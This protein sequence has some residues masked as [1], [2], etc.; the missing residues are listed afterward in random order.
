MRWTNC[1]IPTLKEYPRDATIPSHQLLIKG[2][3]IRMLSAGVYS[4]LPMG[5][6]VLLKVMDIVRQEMNAIGAQE[7]YLPA[8]TPAELWQKTGR[9]EEYGDEMFRIK[10]RKGRDLALAPT[11]EEIITDLARREIRSYRDLPQMWYQIQVKFRDEIRPRSGV[12][13][14]RQFIM[15]DSY[16]MDVDEDGLDKSYGLHYEA[17]KRIF[18]RAGLRY[19]IVEASSGL[20]GGSAS[21]EFMVPSPSGE[22]RIVFC[23]GCGY[24]ANAEVARGKPSVFNWQ[25]RVMEKVHTPVEGSAERIAEYLGVD[26]RQI[27]KSLLY[28]V[29]GKPVFVVIRG[30]YEVNEEKLAKLFGNVRPAHPDEVLEYVGAPVGYV[31]PVGTDI[32]CYVDYSLEGAKGLV[33]GANEEDY[34]YVGLNI[35]EHIVPNKFVD[36]RMV[37]SGDICERCGKPLVVENAIELGHIFKLGTKYSKAI[38]AV[39]LDEAGTEKPIVMGSYGIGIERIMATAIE[40]YNDSNGIMWPRSIAPFE[41]IVS[42]LNVS[43][44]GVRCVAERCYAELVAKGVE[45]LYDDRDERAGVKFKDADLVGIPLRVTI[46]ERGLSNGEVELVIRRTGEV[47][48]VPPDGVVGKVLEILNN[49]P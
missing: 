47:I 31:S 39:Y 9:W 30:D 2:G 11:H 37:N 40:L 32:P 16:S 27:A 34:H 45:V 43:S 22:D 3:F 28:I 26:I 1:F 12:L 48:K 20:M 25:E 44:P 4:Y 29:D 19:V 33:S 13:R 6:K 46:G 23:E 14:A 24:S 7:L 5:W 17:Y 18:D 10:D 36:V 8:L 49:L 38:G 42:P 41:V 15:K 21:Q 35:G